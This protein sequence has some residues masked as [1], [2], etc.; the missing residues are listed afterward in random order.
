VSRATLYR[1]RARQAALPLEGKKRP[2]L[3]RSLS[4][5]EIETVLDILHCERFVDRAP[6]EVYATLLDEGVYHCSIST[7]YR[8][9]EENKEVRERRNQL[10]HPAYHKPELLAAGPNQ[11]WS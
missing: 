10:A 1:Q 2:S 5:Q 3:P 6:Y 8:I 4:L 7:I 11:L 9:L